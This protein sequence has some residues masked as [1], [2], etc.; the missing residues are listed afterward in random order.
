[1]GRVLQI[2]A[3][4]MGVLLLV[5]T[6]GL[7][8]RRATT[9]PEYAIIYSQANKDRSFAVVLQMPAMNYSWQITPTLAGTIP[10]ISYDSDSISFVEQETDAITTTLY[11]LNLNPFEQSVIATWQLSNAQYVRLASNQQW[12]SYEKTD[13]DN[14]TSCHLLDVQT[15]HDHNLTDLFSTASNSLCWGFSSDS[16][17]LWFNLP[18]DGE[19]PSWAYAYRMRL[20]DGSIENIGERFGGAAIEAWSLEE[21]KVILLTNNGNP[22][23]N[24]VYRT[25][26]DNI[27]WQPILNPPPAVLTTTTYSEWI[28]DWL[29]EQKLLIVRVTYDEA[30]QQ[31][32]AV[33]LEGGS[34]LWI[35]RNLSYL[36]YLRQNEWLYFQNNI[37]RAYRMHPDGTGFE[38]VAELPIG[39]GLLS[40]QIIEDH[41]GIEW[42][43]LGSYPTDTGQYVVWRVRLGNGQLEKIAES[44]ER[45]FVGE[46][47]PDHQWLLFATTADESRFTY[48]RV[49][50]D[51]TDKQLL[52]S[53]SN[54][55]FLVW[56][57]PPNEPLQSALL[58]IIGIGLIGTSSFGK[59]PYHFTCQRRR[60]AA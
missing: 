2:G 3:G 56:S 47:S 58:L 44:K 46:S 19:F 26:P 30:N 48:Y 32:V 17:W 54:S 50:L 4:V 43:Y 11:R 31:I 59:R 21:K 15:G 23:T 14:H 24:R 1:M 53:D 13:A 57:L 33:P 6:V 27:Q 9:E 55:R 36:S 8:F 22:Y 41:D 38:L 40:G 52:L 25:D 20:R 10:G 35:V 18:P 51:G 5:M 45:I 7:W 42:F 49:R 37:N 16:Q 29:P 39:Y 28:E 12:I 60:P 34:P